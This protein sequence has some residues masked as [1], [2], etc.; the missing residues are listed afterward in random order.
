M[1]MLKQIFGN[2]LID[3][4]PVDVIFNRGLI[5]DKSVCRGAAGE[6][7]G[8]YTQGI[9]IGEDSFPV[10]YSLFIKFRWGKVPKGVYSVGQTQGVI[11]CSYGDGF[12]LLNVYKLYRYPD[13]GD[14]K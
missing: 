4:T 11:E 7:T 13:T 2:R 10:F 9:V 12:G 6:F 3:L 5:N 1:K 14:V 8:L